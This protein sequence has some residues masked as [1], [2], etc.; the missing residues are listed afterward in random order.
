MISTAVSEGVVIVIAIV[1]IGFFL[2]DSI[3]G[4]W[5]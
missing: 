5:Q 1:V 4:G 2:F 3:K